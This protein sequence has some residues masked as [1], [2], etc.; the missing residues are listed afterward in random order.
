MS[1]L[2]ENLSG[3][4]SHTIKHIIDTW[5]LSTVSEYDGYT[6][7]VQIWQ[8]LDA[9]GIQREFAL[10]VVR[11]HAYYTGMVSEFFVSEDIELGAIAGW[12][13]Y[14]RLTDFID[15]KHSFSGVGMS[16]SSRLM[17]I[18]LENQSASQ[19]CKDDTYMFLHFTETLLYTLSLLQ[20]FISNQKTCE[21]YPIEAKFGKQLE[22]ADKKW[23]RYV[24][25]LGST[26]LEKGEY[27]IKDL[28]S[29]EVVVYKL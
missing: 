15:K 22:Y 14:D 8:Y 4:Q 12:G 13:R 2:S 29:G 25:I 16:A 7:M 20:K 10:P 5:D 9:M 11:W 26:E 18:L 6:D 17:E 23:C 27:Q 1:M 21:I 3:E 24:V 19:W 28:K